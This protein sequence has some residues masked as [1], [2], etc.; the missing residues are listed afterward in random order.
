M[1]IIWYF[2][3][4]G[5]VASSGRSLPMA[6]FLGL[7]EA[8]IRKS[9]HFI[10]YALLGAS[11]YNLIKNN[12]RFTPAFRGFIALALTSTY[13]IIDEVH[14]TFVP[15]RSGQISDVVLDS[16]AALVGIIIFA[17]IFWLTLKKSEKL[18]HKKAME[19][20]WKQNS[21]RLRLLRKQ[22]K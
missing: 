8:V 18:K 19:K 15:G 21:S 14:Q 1:A 6:E 3:S 11:F 17:S 20:L 2:S 13:A 9:A 10:I 5:E 22:Q 12:L 7:H 16:A 4:E